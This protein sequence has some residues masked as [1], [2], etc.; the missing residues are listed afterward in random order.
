MPGVFPSERLTPLAK[1]NV[2]QQSIGPKLKEA[3]LGWVNF[4]VMRRTH[5][6]L[7]SDLG[8]E[9]KL[10]ADQIGYSLD[11]N[12]N[13]FG[14]FKAGRRLGTCWKSHLMAFKWSSKC[15]RVP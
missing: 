2:W 5:A 6:S 8:I 7:I 9:G 1:E 13:I 11:V 14:D 12:Q 10:V 15:R 3:G 4:Q